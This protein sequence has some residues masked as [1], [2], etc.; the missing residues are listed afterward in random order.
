M[1]K[2]TARHFFQIPGNNLINQ[3]KVCS[4]H[5]GFITY[6]KREYTHNVRD[7]YKSSDIWGDLVSH[8]NTNDKITIGNIYRPHKHNNSNPIIE[9][10]IQQINSIISKLLKENSHAIFTRDF[11]KHLIEMNTRIKYQAYFDQFVTNGFYPKLY[12]HVASQ[13]K[14]VL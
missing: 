14:R 3:P 8:E 11:N 4:E 10:F 9:N 6:L 7:W 5:G 13:R 1:A 12:S 2:T